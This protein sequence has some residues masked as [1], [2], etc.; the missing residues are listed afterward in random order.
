[1][2]IKTAAR[3]QLHITDVGVCHGWL[4][5]DPYNPGDSLGG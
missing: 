1:M 2:K 5:A 4:S 3:V